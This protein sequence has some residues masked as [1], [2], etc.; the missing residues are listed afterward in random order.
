MRRGS[1]ILLHITSLPS[2]FGIGDLGPEAYRFVDFLV[3][4]GQSLWQ[5]LPLGPVGFGA[6]PYSSFCSVAGNPLLISLEQLVDQGDLPNS[7]PSTGAFG[8][9]SRPVDYPAV[10]ARKTPILERAAQRFLDRASRQ[11]KAAYEDFC[12]QNEGAC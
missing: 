9:G 10:E 1:G 6:S 12:K 11:R 2:P 8:V 3:A 4:A 7:G 5:V